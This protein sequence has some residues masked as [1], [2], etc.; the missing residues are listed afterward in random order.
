MAAVDRRRVGRMVAHRRDHHP[1]EGV[2][3]PRADREDE[4]IDATVKPR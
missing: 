4:P 2:P 1:D 3:L